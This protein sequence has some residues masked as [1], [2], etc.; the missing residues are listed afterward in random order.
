MLTLKSESLEA[1]RGVEFAI[2]LLEGGLE[3]ISNRVDLQFEE[4]DYEI[5]DFSLVDSDGNLLDDETASSLVYKKIN[6]PGPALSTDERVWATLSLGPHFEYSRKRWA[7]QIPAKPTPE[8]AHTFLQ[9]H[10]FCGSSRKRY[11]SHSLAR[12]WWRRRYID[13]AL[14]QHKDKAAHLFFSEGY[15]DWVANLLERPN[16][17]AISSVADAIIETSFER[18]VEGG[19]KYDRMLFRGMLTKLDLI[20]GGVVPSLFDY[21][22][23]CDEI[24]RKY[25]AV[26]DSSFDDA[27]D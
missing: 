27:E 1:I 12:L 16:L 18:F 3:A 9:N 4:A 20:A 14:S 6:F 8:E 13:A 26:V 25:Q 5:K 10:L 17:A 21:E 24:N 23:I 19:R 22:K 11:R 7:R 2:E 15:S